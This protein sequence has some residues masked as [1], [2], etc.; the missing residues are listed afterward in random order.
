MH[1]YRMNRMEEGA[2][3]VEGAEIY[4]RKRRPGKPPETKHVPEPEFD[5]VMEFRFEEG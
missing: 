5:D 2:Q 1:L 4:L 3:P